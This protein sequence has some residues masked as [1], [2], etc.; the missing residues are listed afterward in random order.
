LIYFKNL[1]EDVGSG[2][3]AMKAECAGHAETAS[4]LTAGLGGDAKRSTVIFWNID[5]L[6]LIGNW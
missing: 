2:K 5:R 4:H 1:V 3:M 6:N